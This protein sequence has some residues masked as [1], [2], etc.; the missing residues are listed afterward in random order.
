MCF[1][2]HVVIIDAVLET[3]C[4]SAFAAW[5]IGTL[6][7]GNLLQLSGQLAAADVG[8]AMAVLAIYNRTGQ[9]TAAQGASALLRHMIDA[10]C[11]IAPGGLRVHD[12]ATGAT[13]NP[14]CCFGLE[15]WR[16]W[17]TVIDGQA[18]WLGHS[19]SPWIEHLDRRIRIW[20]DGGGQAAPATAKTPVEITI[21]E[22]PGLVN[23]AHRQL[24]EFLDLVEPWAVALGEPR[25][26][27]LASAI[28]RHFHIT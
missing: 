10:S 12:T 8:T 1:G 14:G 7:S 22:L 16:E 18:P 2:G 4:V 28:G 27:E 11:L 26:R 20:P 24:R 15:T 23:A 13:V 6:P 5:P 21:V 3:F 17:Q 25:A 19:P 9:D